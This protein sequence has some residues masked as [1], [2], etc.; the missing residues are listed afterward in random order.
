[1]GLKAE[2]SITV[3]MTC[4]KSKKKEAKKEKNDLKRK[5]IIFLEKANIK[6]SPKPLHVTD[7]LTHWVS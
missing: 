5:S 6:M 2:I 3:S 4:K 7:I 1:M